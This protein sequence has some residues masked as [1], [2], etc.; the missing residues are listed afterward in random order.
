MAGAA[1]ASVLEA[2]RASCEALAASPKAQALVRIDEEKLDSLWEREVGSAKEAHAKWEL[3]PLPLNFDGLDA[4]IDFYVLKN[5]ISFG[6]SWGPE[7]DQTCKRG[8]KNSTLFGLI[9]MTI[10]GAKLDAETLARVS[11]N[12]V[13][14]HFQIPFRVEAPLDGNAAIKT[15][16]DSRVR[17][18]A[19][20]LLQVMESCGAKLRARQCADFAAL[21]RGAAARATR[22]GGP[23][24]AALVEELVKALPTAADDSYDVA[25]LRLALHRKVQAAVLDLAAN[26]GDRDPCFR[27][28]AADVDRFTALADDKLV[29]VLMREGVLQIV[30]ADLQKALQART[31]LPRRRRTPARLTHAQAGESIQAGGLAECSLRAAAVVAIE[32]L[33]RREGGPGPVPP[34]VLSRRLVKKLYPKGEEGVVRPV[35]KDTIHY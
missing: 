35:C 24:A 10:S 2:V 30:D 8:P 1:P 23:I 26:V 29:A 18:F 12:D 31:P 5:L 20:R 33:A 11:V 3:T 6:A 15:L 7:L 34:A 22:Q 14:Q 28:D 16:V 27:L 9:S 4:E 19:D 17:R 32:R 21:L 25:G 13:E